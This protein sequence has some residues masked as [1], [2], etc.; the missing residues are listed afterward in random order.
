MKI[1]RIETFAVRIPLR[2]ERQMV[3]ALGEHRVSEY[4]LVR[5]ETEEGVTGVGEAT[6]MPRWSGESVWGAQAMIDRVLAP[7]VLGCDPREVEAISARMDQAAAHNWFA[8]SA[9]EMACWD[10]VGRSV[11]RPVYELLGGPVRERTFGCRFS[12]GAYPPERAAE[13]ARERVRAGFDTLKVKVGGD[14]ATDVARVR[15]VRAAAG[16]GVS[17]VMDANCGWDAETAIR[18]VRALADCGLSLVE[19]PTPDGDYEGMARVRRSIEV[20]VMADDMCFN[21]VH[22]RELLRQGCCDVISVYPGKNGGIGR[23]RAIVELAGQHG[24][25]CTIGSNLEWDV[26][27]AAMGQVIVALANVQVER[28]PGDALGPTYHVASVVKEPLEISGPRVTVPARAGLGVE[29]DWEA[30]ARWGLG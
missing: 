1:E 13:V 23:T 30:V 12:I 15:A 7:A 24:V 25:A 21:L 14:V 3:S 11:G 28:Y 9:L 6:V 22:A 27:T 2:A 29:V 17:L 19:Q 18:A 4:V 8:K 20:P 10:A 16:P 5:L 26:A